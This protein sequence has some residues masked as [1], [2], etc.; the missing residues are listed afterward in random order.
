MLKNKH[1]QSI[2]DYIVLLV[3]IIAALLIMSYYIRNSLS[4]KMRESAD[5]FGGGEVYDPGDTAVTE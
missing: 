2:L 4:G 5:V 3:I 1:A